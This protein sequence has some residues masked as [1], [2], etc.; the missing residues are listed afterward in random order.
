MKVSVREGLD[1]VCVCKIIPGPWVGEWVVREPAHRR[2]MKRLLWT[3][4]EADVDK[5]ACGGDRKMT[6]I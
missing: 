6:N 1:P 2:E 3:W 4:R 5:V